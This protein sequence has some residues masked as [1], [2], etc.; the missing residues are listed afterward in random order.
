MRLWVSSRIPPFRVLAPALCAAVWLASPGQAGELTPVHS[1]A[2][3]MMGC[4][5]G[6]FGDPES[7][8]DLV[9]VVIEGNLGNFAF[10]APE[11]GFQFPCSGI[12]F[13]GNDPNLDLSI[14]DLSQ[15]PAF[16]NLGDNGAIVDA[17]ILNNGTAYA[18]TN[19]SS[20]GASE[21]F[22]PP[23]DTRCN[24]VGMYLS[25]FDGKNVTFA[26]FD[27]EGAEIDTEAFATEPALN[28]FIGVVGSGDSSIHS[29]QISSSE[30]Y[31]LDD[32]YH[33]LWNDAASVDPTMCPEP[34]APLLQ[35]GALG[36][37]AALATRRR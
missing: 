29:I 24:A 3:L 22:L 19:S 28:G 30:V 36:A 27:S 17:S 16:F 33:P 15:G 26:A 14:V 1:V 18:A 20:S 7:F 6:D 4:E 25:S 8:E 2:E 21:F 34:T 9:G 31:A 35:L 12:V 10:G 37:L 23:S 11:P 32:I 13:G 5:T